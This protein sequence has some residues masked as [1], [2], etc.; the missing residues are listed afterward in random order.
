MRDPA[1]T[2]VL[3]ARRNGADGTKCLNNLCQSVL[4]VD[5]KAVQVWDEQHGAYVGVGFH[6]GD[7]VLCTRNLWDQGLQNGSLGVVAQVCERRVLSAEDGE[8]AGSALAWVDWDDGVRRPLN[9]EILDDLELGYAITVHKAQ[10]S[11]WPRVIVPLTG[12]RLLD[13]TLVYT[14]VTR[15]QRQVLLVGD[16]AAAKSAVEGQPRSTTRQVALAFHVSRLLPQTASP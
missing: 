8:E 10:G 15:A 6:L 14:A 5:S 7:R 3:C 12:H 11:Q 1:N 16:S 4:T 2:Q 9:E 13:R